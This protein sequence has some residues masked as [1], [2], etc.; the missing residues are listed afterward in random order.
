MAEI[1]DP[2]GN[3]IADVPVS[4]G[5]QDLMRKGATTAL[6]FHTPQLL[7]GKLGQQEG[8][9]DLSMDGDGKIVA[10]DIEAVKAYARLRAAV[11]A[12]ERA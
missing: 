12:S 1:F 8:T 9:F 6:H 4:E 5:Q 3:L 7:R 2:K 10:S 11:D